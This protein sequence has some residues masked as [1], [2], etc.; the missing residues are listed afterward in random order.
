MTE[1]VV[2][3]VEDVMRKSLHTVDGL[4]SVQDAIEAMDRHAVGSLVIERRHDGDE[5]GLITVYDIADK[6]LS[7]GRSVARTSVYEIMNKPTLTI[8]AGMN[9]KYAIRLLARM[10]ASRA[11]VTQNDELVGLVTLR[12]MVVRYVDTT[13]TGR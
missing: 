6:V 2:V 1:D 5:F 8:S 9:V 3:R 7:E 12:D 10:G 4:A 13:E 11:L